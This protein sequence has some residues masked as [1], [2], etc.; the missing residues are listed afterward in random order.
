[1]IS[2][3]RLFFLF[4]LTNPTNKGYY[5]LKIKKEKGM[6]GFLRN[7]KNTILDI[8]ALLD[9]P[10]ILSSIG[11]FLWKNGLKRTS[12]IALLGYFVN[13]F[14]KV[15]F[16]KAVLPY[17]GI[18]GFSIIFILASILGLF[19]KF[20]GNLLASKS[21]IVAQANFLNLLEDK[22]KSK[23]KKHLSHLW[24]TIFRHEAYLFHTEEEIEKRRKDIERY[25]ERLISILRGLPEDLAKGYLNFDP[26]NNNDIYAF[27]EE[28]DAF[29]PLSSGGKIMT[30]EEFMIS[31]MFAL[32]HPLRIDEEER[33]IGYDIKLLEDWYDGAYFTLNDNKL[34][35]QMKGN[36]VLREI[37][38]MVE[39][40]SI[41]RLTLSLINLNG[42]LW[43]KA[44]MK[45]IEIRTGRALIFL[46]EKYPGY[47]INAEHIFWP[48][49]SSFGSEEIEADI[50]K[51]RKRLLIEI[52]G[53][54]IDVAKRRL[55]RFQKR[56]FENVFSIQKRFD[57]DFIS[58][59]DENY[60]K[61]MRLDDFRIKRELRKISKQRE[62][63]KEIDNYFLKE[64]KTLS[65][66]EKRVLRMAYLLNL[67]N[68]K[69]EFRK[70]K[71]I[72]QEKIDKIL[73]KKEELNKRLVTLKIHSELVRIE[74]RDYEDELKELVYEIIGQDS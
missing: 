53:E 67:D 43:F 68:I 19:F 65:P 3:L 42:K 27:L 35:E 4:F 20:I 38:S 45:T 6:L 5:R 11:T 22:K 15:I 14:T 60:L 25:R 54:T 58:E 39:I 1:M 52:F 48:D 26:R 31:S 36:A 40:P 9:I 13:L 46:N 55:N 51:I 63:L 23:R 28:I 62:E 74:V 71:T 18:A 66:C 12:M 10:Y 59:V 37:R 70:E 72:S 56:N 41:E 30:E 8:K 44:I 47:E 21:I 24:N 29:R 49:H 34:S 32:T 61:E 16:G 33:L 69:D 7:I 50:E 73:A 64:S 17:S 2:K 57:P